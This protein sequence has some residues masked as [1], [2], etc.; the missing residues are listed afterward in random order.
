MKRILKDGVVEKL[1]HHLINNIPYFKDTGTLATVEN[2]LHYVWDE[3][4]PDID[5][6]RPGEAWLAKIKIYETPDSFATLDRR[7]WT[8]EMASK[9]RNDIVDMTGDML[10]T[11]EEFEKMK[12]EAIED[13]D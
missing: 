11:N 10:L 5:A 6:L 4:Q 2:I 12:M 8:K 3:I 13:A 9:Y 7:Q 1:D